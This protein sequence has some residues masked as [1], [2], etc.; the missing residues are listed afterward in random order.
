MK[1]FHPRTIANPAYP[2]ERV[3]ITVPCRKCVACKKKFISDW[4]IRLIDESKNQGRHYFITLTYAIEPDDYSIDHIQQFLKKLRYDSRPNKLRYFIVGERGSD[5][6]RVHYHGIVYT[7]TFV[8]LSQNIIENWEHG[9]CYLGSVTPKS[10]AY[11]AKYIVPTDNDV[12]FRLM[13]RRP[14]LGSRK[15]SSEYVRSQSQNPRGYFYSNGYRK[16]LPRYYRNKLSEHGIV[17]P[18]APLSVGYDQIVEYE[19]QHGND[20]LARLKRGDPTY[21]EQQQSLASD[22]YLREQKGLLKKKRT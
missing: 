20:D 17:L 6:N 19:S 8:D 14:G 4:V 11:V 5:T 15:I 10:C 1:C 21:R 9:F 22:L 18:S 7:D 13:S 12:S 2:G 16:G 3:M